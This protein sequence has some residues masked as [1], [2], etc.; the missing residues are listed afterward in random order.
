MHAIPDAFFDNGEA[1]LMRHPWLRESVGWHCLRGLKQN[2]DKELMVDL[3]MERKVLSSTV[4]LGA[5]LALAQRWRKTIADQRV[6]V[7]FPPGAGGALANLALVL[8]GKVPVNL[9]FT[10]G[11]PTLEITLKKAEI[12][13]V[14]TV[15]QLQSKFADFPWPEDTRDL[16]KEREALGKPCLIGWIAAARLLPAGLLAKLGGVEKK[17]GE[18]EAGLLF[19]S[20]STGEPKGVQLSH[21]NILAN[22]IQV[23]ESGVLGRHEKLL[24]FLPIFHSFGF[25]VTLWYPLI[26]G[27]KL[28]TLPSPLDQ[29]R[30]A[31]AVADEKVTI[32]VGAPTFYRPHFKRTDPSLLASLKW[33]VGGAEKTP[34]GFHQQWESTF[35]SRYLEGYGLTETSPVVSA[36]LPER[37]ANRSGKSLPEAV[38]AGSVGRL[39]YGMAARITDAA[40][41]EVLPMGAIGMLELRGANVFA[42]Y[43]DNPDQTEAV[44]RDGWFITGDLARLDEDGYLYIEG[45]VSRFSKIGGEMVPHGTVEQAVSKALGLDDSEAPQVAITG[46]TDPQK[47]EA[48]VLLSTQQLDVDTLRQTLQAAGLPNLWIPRRMVKVDTIPMLPSGKLDLKGMAKRAAEATTS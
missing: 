13:T 45:R 5:G 23:D 8:A 32:L 28:V 25:T 16:L 20:G 42:G 44:F 48:L 12:K 22:C 3:T 15:K 43:L 2:R 17:G 9:N 38:R 14:I 21:R 35:G 47:G 27:L 19:S 34:A 29:K 24:A 7:V 40:S 37:L 31:Q 10:L 6:G 11:R 33:V 36:N 18:K 30:I 41:G 26:Y 4:L 46:V 39:F 1:E